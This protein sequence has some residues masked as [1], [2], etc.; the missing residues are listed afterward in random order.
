MFNKQKFI[1]FYA[2]QSVT[3]D[4]SNCYD[5]IQAALTKFGIYSDLVMA[6]AMA[7]VRVETAR[8]F[9]PIREFADGSA[10]EGRHDLGNDVAGDGPKFKGRGYIQLTGRYNYE[11]YLHKLGVDLIGNPDLA[12]NVQ[13]AAEIFAR[14]FKDRGC[15]V[16]CNAQNWTRVRLLVNGG[17]NGL[18]LFLSVIAQYLA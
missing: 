18:Q 14:Y 17:T 3:Q 8:T 9:K 7:T 4:A 6:G 16:A 13:T 12:L 2:N 11:T 5:A 10:Y 15:D 1:A